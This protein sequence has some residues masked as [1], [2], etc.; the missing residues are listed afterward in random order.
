MILVIDDD[1]QIRHVLRRML[2]VEGYEVAEAADGCEGMDVCRATPVDLVIVD[3]LMPEKDGLETIQE[4]CA[5][6]PSPKIIAMTGASVT[7]GL[8]Y[9]R[10]AAGHLG[11]DLVFQKPFDWTELRAAVRALV[12]GV[13]SGRR[14]G[15]DG[16]CSA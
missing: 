9:L 11:A 3:L 5:L 16:P 6:S 12:S 8:T 15:T 4:L 7:G 10:P 14:T 2:E 1:A 13:A